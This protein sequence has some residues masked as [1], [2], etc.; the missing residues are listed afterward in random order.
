[1]KLP[2]RK[3]SQPSK[4]AGINPNILLKKRFMIAST[5]DKRR[6]LECKNFFS[7]YNKISSPY[8]LAI[9]E[10]EYSNSRNQRHSMMKTH[11]LSDEISLIPPVCIST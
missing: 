10:S 8:V 4:Y 2:S 6:D 7:T 9:L 3:R 5:E 1:M 11:V